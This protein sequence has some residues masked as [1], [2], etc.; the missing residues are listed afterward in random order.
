ML[1]RLLAGRQERFGEVLDQLEPDDLATVRR[2]VSL[3]R[4]AADQLLGVAGT[5][6]QA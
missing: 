1:E 6:A 2:A 3:L 4:G 5:R